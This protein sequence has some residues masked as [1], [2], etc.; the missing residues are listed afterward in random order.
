MIGPLINA[1]G[2]LLGASLALIVKKPLSARHQRNLKIGLGA[3]TVFY[4]LQLT[5]TSL[6]GNFGQI[7]KQLGV[8]LLAMVFG[9]LIGKLLHIQKGS[10]RLGQFASR[11]IAAASASA[12]KF[13]EGFVVCTVLFCAA[14][15]ATL[16]S[17]QEGFNDF[18][19]LFVIKGLMDG[20]AAMAFAAMYGRGV[21]LSVL[22]VLALQTALTR[23]A[24]LAGP[25]LRD[26]PWPL[27][28]SV[29]ATNGMLIFCVAL[30]ILQ[31]RRIEI[32]DYLPSLICAPLFLR[33]FW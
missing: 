3:F 32:A 10:N 4:G 30:V 20:A 5:V 31:L 13:N 1:V 29:L 12:D 8:V 2:I 24:H 22:P 17:I 23:L 9:K 11:K 7:F 6:H 25:A 28:D 14:P 21:L 27:A 15:L 16:A 26:N 19:P 18:S 33:I